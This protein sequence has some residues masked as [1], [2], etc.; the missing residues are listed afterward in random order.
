[1]TTKR[2][3][4]ALAFVSV[5]IASCSSHSPVPVAPGFPA[6]APMPP[7]YTLHVG[8][9]IAVKFYHNPELNEEVAIRPDGMISLQLIGDVHAA[10]QTPAALSATLTQLYASELASPKISVI[11][12]QLGG[13]QIYVG[14]EVGKPGII[15]MTSGLSLY[16]ALQAAGGVLKTGQRSNVVLIRRDENALP[17]GQIVDIRPIASGEHPEND[18]LLRPTDVVVVPT[19][20]VVDVNIFVEQYIRN[21]LPITPGIGF[22]TF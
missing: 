18:V 11:V 1:M 3:W 5:L 15:Q 2:A 19:S 21:N 12:R 4:I 17:K 20:K 22:T 7:P 10:G 9:Q 13:N 16:Q 6:Q 8:D 14:G